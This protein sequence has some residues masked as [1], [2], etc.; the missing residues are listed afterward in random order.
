MMRK[1]AALSLLLLGLVAC[2]SGGPE[3]FSEELDTPVVMGGLLE[4]TLPADVAAASLDSATEIE[5]FWQSDSI[6]L[7]FTSGY[8]STAQDIGEGYSSE[9]DYRSHEIELDGRRAVAFSFRY[10]ESASPLR[11]V[12]YRAVL[13]VPPE[14]WSPGVSLWANCT[15]KRACNMMLAAY[16]TA[17][18]IGD[19]TVELD[20]VAPVGSLAEILL[21][22][23]LAA[24][25]WETNS[26]TE[27]TWLHE[28]LRL[29]YSTGPGDIE[30][31]AYAERS[32][33]Q[34]RKVEVDGRP[35]VVAT[36]DATVRS[37]HHSARNYHAMLLVPGDADRPGL[38]LLADCAS[39]AD[40]EVML[41]AFETLR[42]VGQ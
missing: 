13:W 39:P 42:F 40:C 4:V 26:E 6:S 18:F 3:D 12:H 29:Q 15:T 9:E 25:A 14:P 41:D 35:A 1:F 7:R 19:T 2:R 31:H 16:E 36:F 33:Y 38:F 32:G 27:G 17:H 24:A 23:D 37:P 22:R 34:E 20:T 30:S 21:P 8:G 5:Q 10:G 28:R 11:A